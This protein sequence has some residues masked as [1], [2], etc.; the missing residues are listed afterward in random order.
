MN[1][2]LE[3]KKLN[4]DFIGAFLHLGVYE[5]CFFGCYQ[6]VSLLIPIASV[7]SPFVKCTLNNV[8]STHGKIS[9]H[10]NHK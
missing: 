2:C 7:V 3:D 5:M 8:M 9:V 10:V 1:T 6:C 4:V